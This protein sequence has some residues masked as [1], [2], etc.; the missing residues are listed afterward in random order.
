MR[1]LVA[2]VPARAWNSAR[3]R[4]ALA[5]MVGL[6]ALFSDRNAGAI[7]P[8]IT[9][10]ARVVGKHTLQLETW[11]QVDRAVPQHWV[12]PAFGP[13]DW[14]ELTIGAVHGVA[15]QGMASAYSIAGPVL[16]TKV[17][18]LPAKE[19]GPPGLA[20]VAGALTPGGVGALRPV[21]VTP[22]VYM[23]ATEALLPGEQVLIHANLG[24]TRNTLLA[25]W[26]PSL[27]AGLGTQIRAFGGLHGVAEV[28]WNDAYA[29]NTG[30]ASQAGARYIL[31][32][33]VQIDATMGS[34]FGRDTARPT[35]FSAG[36]RLV[37]S[38]L[39]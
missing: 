5:G 3:R 34:G 25:G 2:V 35:W 23:A 21:D 12:L 6:L 17:L 14:M 16:Q 18:V 39:W 24:V 37:G 31:G 29:G 15:D 22:F 36:L 27:T 38:P 20:F 26:H 33:H 32:D 30:A 1:R 11:V 13:T 28:F 4:V 8:F 19:N 7:R 9:D 10:D